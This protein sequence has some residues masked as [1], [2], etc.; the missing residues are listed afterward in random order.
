MRL[1]AKRLC[2]HVVP[3]MSMLAGFVKGLALPPS[4]AGETLYP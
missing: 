3:R 1:V 2:A 4:E